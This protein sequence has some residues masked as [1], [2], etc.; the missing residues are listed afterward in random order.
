MGEQLEFDFNP[1]QETGE[2]TALVFDLERVLDFYLQHN[3]GAEVHYDG[4]RIEVSGGYSELVVPVYKIIKDPYG[5][6]SG[7]HEVLT[8]E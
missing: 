5:F 1:P 2:K 6:L 7:L 3:Y 4:E 8:D